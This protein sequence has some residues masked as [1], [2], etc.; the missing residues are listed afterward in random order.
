MEPNSLVASLES[1]DDVRKYRRLL[2]QNPGVE[3]FADA[4]FARVAQLL[5]E[6]IGLLRR[7]T[8]D[9][10]AV[11]RASDDP[12]PIHR[13]IAV[14]L[15]VEG[16]WGHAA[17][18]FIAAGRAS[19]D[20]VQRFALQTGAVDSL[21]RAG[22]V[23][24]AVRLGKRL[25]R[26]LVA[27]GRADL[28]G[29]VQL[30]VGNALLWQDRYRE[31]RVWLR[32]AADALGEHF[33][34]EA[35]SA[36]LALSTSELYGGSARVAGDVAS[37]AEVAFASLDMPVFVD[38]CRLNVAQSLLLT[39]RADE[40]VPLLIEVRARFEMSPFDR[41]RVEEFLGDAFANLN[42]WS[43]ASDA[44][45]SALRVYP[46]SDQFNRANAYL[47]QAVALVADGKPEEAAKL[48]RRAVLA[49]RRL[50]NHVWE[51][52]ALLALAE[53]KGRA[54][55][56]H[57]INR[58]LE[59]LGSAG[60]PSLLAQAKL[61]WVEAN[62]GRLPVPTLLALVDQANKLIRQSG[63]IGQAWRPYSLRAR[64]VSGPARM[65]A[66]R[67]M[68]DLILE[69]RLLLQSTTARA[70]F[71]GD[72]SEAIRAYLGELL[73]RGGTQEVEEALEV[74][75]RCRSGALIDEILNA[76]AGLS[77]SQ[78]RELDELRAELQQSGESPGG[79]ARHRTDLSQ[80]QLHT[81]Q[82]RWRETSWELQRIAESQSVPRQS[83]QE[84]LV[85]VD[86]DGDLYAIWRGRSVRLGIS[87]G[88][89][90][91]RLKWLEFDLLAPM[92]DRKANLSDLRKP[93]RDL[94]HLLLGPF[95]LS[96]STSLAICPDGDLWRVP[97]PVLV[98]AV[99]SNAEV[100]LLGSPSFDARASTRQ[101]A[102]NPKAMLWWGEAADLPHLRHEAESFLGQFPNAQ[103]CR[104]MK[105]VRDS[106]DVSVDVLHVACHAKFVH[107]SPM[108]SFLEFQDGRIHA[109]EIARSPLKVGLTMLSAC[110]TGVLSTAFR[111][112][113]EGLSRAFLSRGSGA[114][115]A[116]GWPLDDE[117]AVMTTKPFYERLRRGECIGDS[118]AAARAVTREASP[119]PYFW[120]AF[121]LFGGY[122]A[123]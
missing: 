53:A 95:D 23:E 105:E 62:L 49:Y 24:S 41:G 108:F 79:G 96:D 4:F 84:T 2:I 26:R 31:A 121:V 25:S 46:R 119:H 103:V 80:K 51:A 104:T 15:R 111:D 100:T 114:V 92:A 66:Y 82:R 44:Y 7:L 47:G 30:N 78:R 106:W 77:D 122:V 18:A 113:P 22:D 21:A 37:Q 117:A 61:D 69:A 36:H 12:A 10:G 60:S 35:A 74:I 63:A 115:L 118:M 109:T 59:L 54:K 57:A 13:A 72:K 17:Q 99:G 71:L 45:R 87:R 86:T 9:L 5:G 11:L 39:G 88:Q 112:E 50:G 81:L 14:R 102:E 28:A 110:E 16:R 29:R 83:G 65:R 116:S 6:D 58:A 52:A 55:S 43:E 98:Q 90:R 33:P 68:L 123:A 19:V 85:F 120:G 107:R 38:L 56:R 42:L 93:L 34:V 91:E 8:R 76:Q 70:S 73:R 20:P 94:A 89:L 1:A 3:G 67:R 48:A 27:L 75:R 97:W 64:I 40:A 101:L 32:R